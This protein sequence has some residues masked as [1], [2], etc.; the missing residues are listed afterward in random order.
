MIKGADLIAP[1]GKVEAASMFPGAAETDLAKRLQSYLDEGYKKSES[2]VDTDANVQAAR[3]DDAASHWAYYRVYE[4][5]FLRMS[6]SPTSWTVQGDG[7]ASFTATQIANFE[8][9]M[10]DE[11][12]AHLALI[13]SDDGGVI[14]D[15]QPRTQSIANRVVW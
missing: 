4:A 3:R 14:E 2:I 10:N 8:R 11:L 15:R 13:P 9:L 5:V 7:S 6:A 1:K 12:A